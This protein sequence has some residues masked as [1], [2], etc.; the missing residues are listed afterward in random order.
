MRIIGCAFWLDYAVNSIGMGGS[1]EYTD[2][3]VDWDGSIKWHRRK[4]KQS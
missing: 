3:L 1:T 4:K 2:I